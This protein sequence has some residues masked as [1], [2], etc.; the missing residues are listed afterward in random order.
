MLPKS[1]TVLSI[2]ERGKRGMEGEKERV[3]KEG[4]RSIEEKEGQRESPAR[5]TSTPS[6]PLFFSK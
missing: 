3:R 4:R 2:D 5:F 6:D 1:M